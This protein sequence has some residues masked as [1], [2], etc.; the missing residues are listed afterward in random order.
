MKSVVGYI[1][2]A[3]I[4]PA[5]AG[6]PREILKG[7]TRLLWVPESENLRPNKTIGK[8][9][10]DQQ[11]EF[12]SLSEFYI[13]VIIFLNNLKTVENTPQKWKNLNKVK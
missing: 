6:P 1:P 11:P 13:Y 10:Y 4:G 5:H 8:L 2:M 3:D 9:S 7:G 12:R